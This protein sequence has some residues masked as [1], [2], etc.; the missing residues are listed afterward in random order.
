MQTILIVC[1]LICCPSAFGIAVRR[2]PNKT[3]VAKPITAI[4]DKSA[5]TPAM[6]VSKEVEHKAVAPEVQVAQ[7]RAKLT[8]ISSG[9]SKMLSGSAGKTHVGA[10]MSKV[11]DELQHV[12]MATKDSKDVKKALKQLQDANMAVKQMSTDVSQEQVQLM[13]ESEEQEQSL[14]LGV[15]MQRQNDPMSKQ[16]EVAASPEFA[17]LPVVVAVLAAKDMKTPLFKQIALY[18]D[19][20][21]S[22]KPRQAEPVIPAKLLMGRDGKPDVTPIVSA[23]EARLHKME[24]NEKRMEEHHDQEMQELDRAAKEK[25]TDKRAVHQILRLKKGDNRAFAKQAA[26]GKHDIETMKTAI[27]A[28]KNGDMAGLSKAQNALDASMKAAQARTGKFLVFVQLVHRAEGLDCPYCAA[29]CVDKCHNE[30]KPYT[31]CL[32]VCADAGKN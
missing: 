6:V 31:T 10:M 18:L 20:H 15:L 29:Q 28:V 3:L 24:D 22:V 12:L 27:D 25:K 13:H 7:L 32:T 19:A 16:L 11:N 8:K 9:F 14:L 1:A 30:G 26:L 21:A 4:P 5:A 23:L 17:K 2:A